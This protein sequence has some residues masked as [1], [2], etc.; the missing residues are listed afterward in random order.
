[1]RRSDYAEIVALIPRSF[2]FKIDEDEPL[3]LSLIEDL[4][5]NILLDKAGYPELEVAIS[6]QVITLHGASSTVSV[7]SCPPNLWVLRTSLKAVT[8]VF[9]GDESIFSYI[10]ANE[11][12]NKKYIHLISIKCHVICVVVISAIYVQGLVD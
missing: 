12:S 11:C 7:S 6:R 5:P 2:L 9:F 8:A 10:V 1:M 4:F 3:F